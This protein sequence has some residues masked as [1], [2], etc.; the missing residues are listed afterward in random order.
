VGVTAWNGGTALAWVVLA[1]WRMSQFGPVFIP[2][3]ATGLFA[4][5][6]TAMALGARRNHARV[7]G[8]SS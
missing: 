3:L 1:A 4:C 8:G 6:I 2:L 5:V 7:V